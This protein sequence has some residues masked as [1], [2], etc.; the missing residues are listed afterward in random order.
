MYS[1][2]QPQNILFI[3]KMIFFFETLQMKFEDGI[4]SF[5]KVNENCLQWI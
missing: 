3:I 2:P 4:H 5:Y 1:D